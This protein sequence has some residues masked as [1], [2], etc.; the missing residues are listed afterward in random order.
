[1]GG[2]GGGCVECVGCMGCVGC[3]WGTWGERGD[4]GGAAGFVCAVHQKGEISTGTKITVAF[5]GD[6]DVDVADFATVISRDLA[7]LLISKTW[8]SWCYL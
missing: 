8:H 1:V 2:C 7:T 3:V 6:I 4:G 5:P